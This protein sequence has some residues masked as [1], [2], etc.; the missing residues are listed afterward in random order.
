MSSGFPQQSCI[1]GIQTAT[2]IEMAE[3]LGVNVV[4]F[5]PAEYAGGTN[6]IKSWES[7]FP[8]IKFIPTGGITIK[9]MNDYLMLKNV[10]CVGGSWIAKERLINDGSFTEISNNAKDALKRTLDLR[11]SQV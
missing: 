2:E 3:E 1:P 7:V 8:N 4:K 9:T 10:L 6:M 11:L 5:F